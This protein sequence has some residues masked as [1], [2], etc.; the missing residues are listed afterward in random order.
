MDWKKKISTDHTDIAYLEAVNRL[1]AILS[2]R[3]SSLHLDGTS[4]KQTHLESRSP[5]TSRKLDSSP[6]E[7]PLLS[8]PDRL[9]LR[10]L[11]SKESPLKLFNSQQYFQ[12][13]PLL[14]QSQGN[15]NNAVPSEQELFDFIHKQGDYINQLETETKY[16]RE[17]LANMLDK[18]RDVI[19]ENETLHDRQKR[20]TLNEKADKGL[21]GGAGGKKSILKNSETLIWQSKVTEL[22]AQLSQLKRTLNLAQEEVLYLRNVNKTNKNT[23][24]G[25]ENGVPGESTNPYAYCDLHREEIQD[26]HKEKQNFLETLGKFKV[27]VNE[28]R[29]REAEAAKKVLHSLDI[30]ETMEREKAESEKE[31]RRL[32]EDLERHQR[33]VAELISENDRRVQDEKAN[34]EHKFRQEIEI[35]NSSINSEVDSLAR[36]KLELERL[37]RSELE[38]KRQV[39]MKSQTMDDLRQ[40]NVIRMG[41]LQTELSQALLGKSQAEQD[42]INARLITEKTE[43]DGKQQI[44]RLQIELTSLRHRIESYDADLIKA[45]EIIVTMNENIIHLQRANAILKQEGAFDDSNTLSTIHNLEEKHVLEMSELEKL[46]EEQNTLLDKLRNECKMLTGKL[47]ETSK[48][49]KRERTLIEREKDK[50]IMTN[51]II[52]EKNN[53]LEKRVKFYASSHEQMTARLKKMEEDDKTRSERIF[54]LLSKQ[55]GLLNENQRLQTELSAIKNTVESLQKN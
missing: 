19:T 11:L 39:Q 32:K 1:R 14:S 34:L 2:P 22:E 5:L 23:D 30:V 48:L 41:N 26:L 49:Q 24:D 13:N 10:S 28:L 53:D 35:L 47:D 27:T 9:N 33:R 7:S 31:I 55:S 3:P 8:R 17:D 21:F 52:M 50:V 46:I 36:A 25:N 6:V 51:K 38:L 16:C 43:R 4:H 29:E 45:Q 20:E 54:H 40:E 44:S 15:N 12:N 37:K 18:V 42:L